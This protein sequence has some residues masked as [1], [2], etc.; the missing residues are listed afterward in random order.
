M[1]EEQRKAIIRET[2]KK[3]REAGKKGRK[4]E[5]KEKEEKNSE[6]IVAVN[7]LR[8]KRNSQDTTPRTQT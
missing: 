8:A 7:V 4:E 3:V 6:K 5:H 1:E 2:D